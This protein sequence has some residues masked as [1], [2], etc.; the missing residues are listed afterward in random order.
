M[1]KLFKWKEEYETGIKVIDLQHKKIFETIDVLF[2]AVSENR[3][4]EVVTQVLDEL[5]QYAAH[6]FNFEESHFEKFHFEGREA[7][8]KEHDYYRQRVA[9]FA[10]TYNNTQAT[11]V[12]A[13]EILDFLEDWWI[14]HVTGTDRKYIECFREYGLV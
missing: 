6:H 13:F 10:A 12:E 5:I 7:H 8:I 11:N 14:D 3:G 2:T 1:A 4:Q 9:E